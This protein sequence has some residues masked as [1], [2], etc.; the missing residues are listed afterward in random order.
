MWCLARGASFITGEESLL[1]PRGLEDKVFAW[2]F[3][4][5]VLVIVIADTT[6]ICVLFSIPYSPKWLMSVMSFHWPSLSG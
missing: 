1:M 5:V 4:V 6:L 2:M 3:G